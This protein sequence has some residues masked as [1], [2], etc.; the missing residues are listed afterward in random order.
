MSAGWRARRSVP[1]TGLEAF[2]KAH[3]VSRETLALLETYVAL[4]GD[5]NQRHNLVS[6]KSLENVWHRH[7]WDSAQLI[8]FVPKTAT[9]LVD[10][11]SGA[12]FPGIVLAAMLRERPQFRTVLYE[13]IAKKCRFLE[14]V[15]GQLKLNVEVRNARMEEAKREPFGLVTARACAPLAKLLGYARPFQDSRTV[16]LFLKGQNVESELTEARTSWRMKVVRHDS[17]TDPSGVTLEIRDLSH[18]AARRNASR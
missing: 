7:V 4:L 15:A 16:N 2:A 18:V 9:S 11:G 3:D 12:G 17:L 5:W 14:E 1:D 13:S 10:L 6:E 8:R